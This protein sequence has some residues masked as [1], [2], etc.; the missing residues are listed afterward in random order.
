MSTLGRI[1][2]G[3]ETVV[4]A[5]LDVLGPEGT[6]VAYTGWQDAPPDD[7]EGSNEE[8]KR[9]Y[10][11]EHP[12]YDPRVAPSSRDH[13]RV[14][15]ALR[16]WPGS[17]HNGHPE[18]GVAAIGALAGGINAGHPFDDA[19]GADTPY[20]RLVQSGGKVL[21]LGAP[22]ETV[23]LVHHAEAIANVPDKRPTSYGM[24]VMEEDLR[25]WRTF[26]DIDTEHGV[27]PYADVLGD[28]DYVEYIAR[29]ALEA[30]AGRSGSVGGTTC[31]LFD[32]RGLVEHAVRWIERTFQPRNMRAPGD[33]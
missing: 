10:L 28:E 11:E 19:Y 18:A 9:I 26:S 33:S 30:D 5:L 23:T 16:T 25:V 1:A 31:Y 8:E 7:L 22:L 27:L 17:L 12:A 15:E 13:G 21:L 6:L 3:A 32:A 2:G 24:P 4:R 20:D 14:P 29:S